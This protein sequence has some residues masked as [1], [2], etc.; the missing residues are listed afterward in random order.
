MDSSLH[1]GPANSYGAAPAPYG[2]AYGSSK[3]WSGSLPWFIDEVDETGNP[4]DYDRYQ[5][6][7]LWRS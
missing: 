2:G 3:N 5:V 7:L 1:A 4:R 6:D